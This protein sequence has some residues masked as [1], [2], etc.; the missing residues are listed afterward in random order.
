MN[1][2]HFL[3]GLGSATGVALFAP[4]LQRAWADGPTPRRFVF[5]VEGN[6]IESTNFMTPATRSGIAAQ[7]RSDIGN[8]RYYPQYYGHT[9]PLEFNDALSSA[10]SLSP[11]NDGSGVNLD[12]L[13]AVVL[14]L[15]SRV[16]GGGHT[17][18]FGA[19]SC[20]RSTPSRPGGPTI[21]AVLAA[22][23]EVR[24]TTPFDAVRLGVHSRSAA[25][26]TST[27]AYG[28]GR[29][30]PVLTQPTQAFAN[31]FGAVGDPA[32]RAAFARRANLIDY[33]TA[34]A[35][36]ALSSFSGNSTERAKLEAYLTSLETVSIRQ[37]QLTDLS[38]TLASVAPPN[39]A[40]SDLYTSLDPFD[41]LQAHFD[42]VQAAL[43]GGLTNVAVLA[44]GTGGGFDLEYPSLITGVRRH[45]L[46]HMYPNIVDPAVAVT[47][48][49]DAT[50]AL[51][52]QA[53]GLARALYNTPE[54][55]GTML[56]NTLIVVMSDNGE[57]HH[58]TASE[59]PVLLI[60]GQNMGLHTDGR[61][62]VFPGVGRS[63]NRQV[64]NL[65]NTLGYGA[66]VALDRF[67]AEGALR[68]AP[69]PLSELWTAI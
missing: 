52:A 29:A 18:N 60:G 35:T 27:C 17:T 36:A 67:G 3:A 63:S 68:I 24:G 69:G 23:S 21:D 57:Q 25:M 28:V 40:N 58:S 5:V 11:L 9:S 8:R 48:I 62:T 16:T 32:S 46:H 37:Q 22:A 51:V 19:L 26:N 59:W 6:G 45:D 43:Q 31:L 2:R 66:G 12:P 49:R 1:R 15:S 65:F 38:P 64:S 30:A 50:Q 55:G 20:S 4:F 34:D 7:L 44:A 13:S 39:P 47:I 41:R 54:E 42:M 10:P 14:G 56:D 33:A 61:S 53:A